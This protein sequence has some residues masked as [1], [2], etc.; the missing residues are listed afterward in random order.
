MIQNMEISSI[1]TNV[2][3]SLCKNLNAIISWVN[4]VGMRERVVKSTVAAFGL[5]WPTLFVC[6]HTRNGLTSSTVVNGADPFS[7]F[8]CSGEEVSALVLDSCPATYG[9]GVLA[10]ACCFCRLPVNHLLF[11]V[12]GP[13]G[14]DGGS[15]RSAY[16]T[17]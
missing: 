13:Q 9:G 14:V 10:D 6:V 5:A 3:R 2:N 17:L 11:C 16:H 12:C 8:Q 1:I 4:V 7:K 15:R